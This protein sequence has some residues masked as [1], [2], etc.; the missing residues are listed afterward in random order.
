[1]SGDRRALWAGTG[2]PGGIATYFRVM[3]RTAL[4][5]DWNVGLIVTHQEGS[6]ATKIAVFVSAV[7]QF[8]VA[9]ARRR[10]DVVHLHAASDTSLLRKAVLLML[11]RAVRV[12]VILHMH[13][14]DF[15]DYY[16]ASPPL[17]RRLIR[18][19]LTRS[20]AVVAL[21]DTWLQRLR[22]VAPGARVE[23]IPNAVAP[24]R[25]TSGP[26]PGEPVHV[27][28]LGRIG[29]RKGALRLLDA[30]EQVAHLGCRLTIAGDGDVTG[31]RERVTDLG[32]DD[33][34]DVRGWLD[35]RA[36]AELLDTAH[37]FALPSR[38]EGQP[39]AVLEAMS[40]GLCVIAGHVGGIPDLI[41]DGCGMLID[42]D[43]IHGIAEALRIAVTDDEARR[44]HGANAYARFGR[45]FDIGVVSGRLDAL[46]REVCR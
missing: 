44:T 34:V 8:V 9:F 46:Y 45:Q 10:P 15:F 3:Q 2:A 37:V 1:M 20:A 14:S 24:Q 6:P 35:E 21:G 11:C 4:W 5:E 16:R 39:M 40:R 36:V 17:R 22:S 42:P 26:A 27:V 13:G 38:N 31:A 25:R 30:W 41:G 32:L 23:P 7:A 18:A 33:S 43:D 29:D 12:P 28:F 19:T